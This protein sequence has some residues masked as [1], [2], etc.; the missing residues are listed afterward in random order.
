MV[1]RSVMEIGD[2]RSRETSREGRT[3]SR[4]GNKPQVSSSPALRLRDGFVSP[5]Y[6]TVG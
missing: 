3:N 1:L 5:G 2:G 4:V 6:V